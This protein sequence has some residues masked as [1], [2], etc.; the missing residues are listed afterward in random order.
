LVFSTHHPFMDWHEFQT[1]SY[2]AIDLLEDEWD[3][4]K[5]TFYRRPL[6][7]MTRDLA[8]AGFVISQILEP[9]PLETLQDVDSE[10]FSRLSKEPL[11]LM[12]KAHK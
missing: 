9:E 10:L 12:F 4:G 5:V 6:T 2:F 1:E 8:E 3:V 11:R 7:I